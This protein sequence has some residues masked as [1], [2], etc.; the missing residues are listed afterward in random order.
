MGL[1]K[2]QEVEVISIEDFPV[3]EGW[4]S[5]GTFDYRK[6]TTR[7]GGETLCGIR[8]YPIA[9]AMDSEMLV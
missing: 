7:S 2:T 9:S 8:G 3:V 6:S 4:Q 1:D 5:N